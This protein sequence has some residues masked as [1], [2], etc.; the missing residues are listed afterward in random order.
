MANSNLTDKD[1]KWIKDIDLTIKLIYL[2]IFA[3]VVLFLILFSQAN[4]M[5][6]Y[7]FAHDYIP[8]L[9]DV[10][11]V[12][13]YVRMLAIVFP[14]LIIIYSFAWLKTQRKDKEL[15]KKILG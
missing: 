10:R 9:V 6:K 4:F 5:M 8:S 1:K 7:I 14:L 13:L 11:V 2:G 3:H 12:V 15:F